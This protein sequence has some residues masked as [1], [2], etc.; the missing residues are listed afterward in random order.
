MVEAREMAVRSREVFND[1]D[2]WVPNLA[3]FTFEAP[4][5]LRL[6]GGKA[7]AGH[8][9]PRLKGFPDAKRTVQNE[10]VSGPL[11]V[12]EC[13]LEGTHTG[14]FDGPAGIIPP[15]GRRVVVK[16]LQSGRYEKGLAT[17]VRLYY[18]QID[19]LTQLGLM[20]AAAVT[21]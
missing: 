7:G 15:T 1:H 19:L 14:S 2:E 12:Q 9:K 5:G 10:V 20:P 13:T 6:D 3:E 8:D 18:D 16:C 11:I 21:S 17:D 4:G